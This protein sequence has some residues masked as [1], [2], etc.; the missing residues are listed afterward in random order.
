MAK[1]I[2]TKTTKK[3]AKITFEFEHN[4]KN[5]KRTSKLDIETFWKLS[6][7][8][9]D[10]HVRTRA[11]HERK[12]IDNSRAKTKKEKQ[13]DSRPNKSESED[14]EHMVEEQN[15][16]TLE[17]GLGQQPDLEEEPNQ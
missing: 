14:L 1:L 4:G 15:D 11:N 7:R 6:D 12:K 9:L 17:S 5:Y 8:E 16:E 3:Y 13:E 10:N 2:E